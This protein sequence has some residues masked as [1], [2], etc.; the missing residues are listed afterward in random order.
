MR[1][2]SLEF[3]LRSAEFDHGR[4]NQT[5]AE[6]ALIWA[7]FG[8]SCAGIG[9][10]RT[11]FDQIEFG[12]TKFGLLRPNLCRICGIRDEPKV[13]VARL[14][15][16]RPSA[17]T[18]KAVAWRSPLK[19]AQTSKSERAQRTLYQIPAVSAHVR[20]DVDDPGRSR[21]R[22]CGLI[23]PTT[24]SSG[25]LASRERE[26]ERVGVLNPSTATLL[27]RAHKIARARAYA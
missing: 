18:P 13:G 24:Q 12:A 4:L 14:G 7:K 20:A 22:A 25:C 21:S 1:R 6:L 23:R 15:A 8:Q 26:R 5:W 11:N 10:T 3:E 27:P 2:N 17:C 19:S 9:Q 16:N